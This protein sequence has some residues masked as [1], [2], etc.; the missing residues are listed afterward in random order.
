MP[1]LIYWQDTQITATG[2]TP[3][4]RRLPELPGSSPA[5]VTLALPIEASEVHFSRLPFH[6]MQLFIQRGA[7]VDGPASQAETLKHV[8]ACSSFLTGNF[9]WC[10][11]SHGQSDSGPAVRLCELQFPHLQCEGNGARFTGI[12]E[13]IT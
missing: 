12:A 7:A 8:S 11:H 2:G 9:S 6:K 4:Q 10:V 13:R 1:H 5:W 3:C